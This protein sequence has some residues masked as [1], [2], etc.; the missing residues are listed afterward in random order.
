LVTFPLWSAALFLFT[1][2]Q[3]LVIIKSFALN[4]WPNMLSAWALT[5]HAAGGMSP[6]PMLG[7]A[8]QWLGPRQCAIRNLSGAE[9]GSGIFA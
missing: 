6:V 2:P 4:V 5:I 1:P 3:K 7:F 8:E 9:A